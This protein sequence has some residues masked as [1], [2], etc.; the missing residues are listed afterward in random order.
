MKSFQAVAVVAVLLGCQRVALSNPPAAP[1]EGSEAATTQTGSRLPMGEVVVWSKAGATPL[2]VELATDDASRERG[3]MF[4]T[5]VPQGHGMLFVFSASSNHTFWM[6]NT[7]VPLDM[8][9]V[10]ANLEI[11]GIVENAEPQTLTSRNPGA[12]S[13][14]VLEVAGGTAFAHGWKKG[15]RLELHGVPA[16]R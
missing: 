11:V 10:G 3:L 2:Q 9:F 5:E 14:Y 4:R 6:K 1:A 13:Q 8:I 16:G 7:L 12:P 15:D